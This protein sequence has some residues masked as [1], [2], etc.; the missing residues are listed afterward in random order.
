MLDEWHGAKLGDFGLARLGDHGAR[1]QTTK[2]VLGTAGYI[3][4]EFVNTRH[5]STE[6][7][8]YSFGIVLLEVVSGR[9]PVILPKPGGGSP[10]FVLLKWVWGLYGQNAILDAVDERLRGGG[11]EVDDRCKERVLVVGLWC[12]HPEQSERPS[13]A[14]AMH[15]LLSKDARLVPVLPP[16]MY[17]N[18]SGRGAL[19]IEFES[20]SGDSSSTKTGD[21]KASSGSSSTALLRDSKERS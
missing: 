3:D 8:V 4:L 2:A 6:S 12:A 15:V 11:D 17:G 13:I 9:A 14:Q 20:Y 21:S 16:R 18:M 19:S 5:P 7:D 1:W 10:P